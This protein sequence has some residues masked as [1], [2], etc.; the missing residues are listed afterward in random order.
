MCDSDSL[1]RTSHDSDS[2][3]ADDH[4]DHQDP[5]L[6]SQ[7]DHQLSVRCTEQVPHKTISSN[8]ELKSTKSTT[9]RDIPYMRYVSQNSLPYYQSR[10]QVNHRMRHTLIKIF[11]Q[12]YKVN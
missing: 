9:N 6:P 5:V 10:A 1:D 3:L 8:L 4:L 7:A 11:S 2:Y 12:E